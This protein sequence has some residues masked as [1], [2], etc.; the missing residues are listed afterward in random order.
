MNGI[1]RNPRTIKSLAEEIIK[2]CDAYWS[3]N[4]SEEVGREYIL[5]WS[6]SEGNKLFKSSE[7][8]STIKK[9]IGKKRVE[10]ISKWIEEI[11]I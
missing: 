5:Y 2:V 9:V 4:I 11:E 3:R 7:L 1:I 10:L 6:K 8:N